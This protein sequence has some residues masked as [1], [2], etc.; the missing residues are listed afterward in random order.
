MNTF[1]LPNNSEVRST[2]PHLELN[3]Y[4]I[5]SNFKKVCMDCLFYYPNLFSIYSSIKDIEKSVNK[6]EK[7][8][9]NYNLTGL[10]F[11]L[12]KD[13]NNYN[14]KKESSKK[15]LNLLMKFQNY[16]NDQENYVKNLRKLFNRNEELFKFIKDKLIEIPSYEKFKELNNFE[17]ISEEQ[18]DSLYKI[19]QHLMT[20][21]HESALFGSAGT[22]KTTMINF[23]L[24]I[25][26]LKD[27]LLFRFIKNNFTLNNDEKIMEEI[28]EKDA[29]LYLR[30]MKSIKNIIVASPTN[31]ALDVIRKKIMEI[32]GLK[33][34][35]ENYIK[36][37]DLRIKMMTISK[38]L[39]Y[40]KF[41]DKNY[42]VT[43]KRGKRNINIIDRYDLII[44]D[45]CS[46]LSQENYKDIREDI[47][48]SKMHLAHIIY[49]GDKSQLPPT[50]ER[51]SKVFDIKCKKVELTKIMRTDKEKIKNMSKLIREWII[52]EDEKIQEKM[53]KNKCEYINIFNHEDKFI[54]KYIKE[55]KENKDPIILVWTNKERQRY[56][57]NIRDI[58][59]GKD[60]KD[61]YKQGEQ[62][63]F[64][65]FYKI[66][67]KIENVK[68][69]YYASDMI[70]IVKVTQTEFKCNELTYE[71]VDG[72]FAKNDII[73]LNDYDKIK[74]IIN[75]FINKFNN[76]VRM[77]FKIW[78]LTFKYRGETQIF[79]INIII[80]EKK[81][82]DIIKEAKTHINTYFAENYGIDERIKEEIMEAIIEAFDENYMQP[83][84][85]VDYGYSMTVDKSQGSTFESVYIDVADI[86]DTVRHPYLELDTAKR[87]FYTAVTRAS[88]EL[89]MLF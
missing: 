33:V 57:K 13:L 59:F 11:I 24:Q 71:Q 86:L 61:K 22:G 20:N 15:N 27:Y 9:M 42:E 14:K 44:I 36:F 51:I 17:Q 12:E 46:M 80:D 18:F 62:L 56:N 23:I 47:E 29:D 2:C 70:N 58:L 6:L 3:E 40:K 19:F 49:T 64:N 65:N 83:F 63:I 67:T 52:K 85:E 5:L 31:K 66:N 50:K 88:N 41:I 77:K 37:N 69:Y 30:H 48:K 34:E 8:E 79:P 76:S 60:N 25:K 73:L 35:N 53:L 21:D 43:F 55:M 26:N 78:S 81:Y 1:L 54:E 74:D 32:K 84:A 10:N 4:V 89:N 28:E 75:N 72:I 87:R 38:L 16:V 82:N 45:E 7:P 68:K 39:S